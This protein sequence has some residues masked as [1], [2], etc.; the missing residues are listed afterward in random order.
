VNG[1]RQAINRPLP[2]VEPPTREEVA[3]IARLYEQWLAEGH[4]ALTAAAL[5]YQVPRLLDRIR[6]LEALLAEAAKG[7]TA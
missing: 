7:R 6:A 2:G 5:I 3:R 4:D 1:C